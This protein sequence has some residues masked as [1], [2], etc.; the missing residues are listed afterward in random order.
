MS[1]NQLVAVAIAIIY[2]QGEFLV[3]LRD[4]TP[5]IVHPG[6]WAL[7]GGHLEKEKNQN[8]H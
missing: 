6:C 1:Q 2:R 4:N 5:K 3:Q 7:F 8:P